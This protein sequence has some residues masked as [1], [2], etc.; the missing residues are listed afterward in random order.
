MLEFIIGSI[1]IMYTSCLLLRFGIWLNYI[2]SGQKYS[3]EE[4]VDWSNVTIRVLTVGESRK[5]VQKTVDSISDTDASVQVVSEKSIDIDDAKVHKV[6]QNFEIQADDKAR[7][8]EWANR[9]LDKREYILFLDE[10]SALTSTEEIPKGD[11]IQLREKPFRSNSIMCWYAGIQRVGVE[12]ESCYFD[13]SDPPYVWGGGL[14]IRSEIEDEIGWNFGTIREDEKF[15][16]LAT[17][18]GYTYNVVEYPQIVNDSPLGI[19]EIIQQRRRWNSRNIPFLQR[20]K[21]E[22]KNFRT[23]LVWGINSLILP[24]T[25]IALLINNSIL[26]LLLLPSI[27]PNLVWTLRG[28]VN[29]DIHIIHYPVI[30]LTLP[31]IS[32]YNGFGNLYSLFNPIDEFNVT[33]KEDD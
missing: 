7:A 5:T 32:F 3:A 22:A 11:L 19:N 8:L 2:L 29:Y 24:L 27:V 12:E 33:E 20:I 21:K 1:I 31:V 26:Y 4:S 15:A 9:N 18:E 17:T 28:A 14:L 25:I 16:D 23:S 10:D 6:P 13:D 30:I